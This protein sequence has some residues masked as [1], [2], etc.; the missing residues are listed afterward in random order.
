MQLGQV[1]GTV[2][3]TVKTPRLHAQRL[4]LVR[5]HTFARE[6]DGADFV[7]VDLVSAGRGEWVLYVKGR[8]AANALADAFN[9]V[10]RA[11]V[12]I[13]DAIGLTA[14]EPGPPPGLES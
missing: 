6:P 4:L 7:A 5:P 8:E 11:L 9:P 10:D 13:V 14:A 2:V 1:I 3:A 12:A